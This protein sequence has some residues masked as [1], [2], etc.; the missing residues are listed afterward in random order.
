MA[1]KDRLKK[2]ALKPK[3]TKRT[4][5]IDG[6]LVGGASLDINSFSEIV[7]ISSQVKKGK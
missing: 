2:K 4:P 3:R 5:D 7:K 6:A 1:L